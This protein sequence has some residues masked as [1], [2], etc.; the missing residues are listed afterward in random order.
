MKSESRAVNRILTLERAQPVAQIENDG[1]PREIDAQIVAQ[2]RD[3]AQPRHS[4]LI[5][6]QSRAFARARL[7]Q[8]A[9]DKTLDD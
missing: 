3:H 8:A 5:E 7:D 2:P 6:K 4:F 9:I 1:N